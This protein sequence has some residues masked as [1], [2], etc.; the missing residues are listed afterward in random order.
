MESTM[1]LK[2]KLVPLTFVL[3]VVF[4]LTMIYLFFNKS[5]YSDKQLKNKNI[6]FWNKYWDYWP[7]FDFGIGDVGKKLHNYIFCIF[8]FKN[9]H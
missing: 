8:Q 5:T 7:D 2:F 4:V 6:L 3:S 9:F 1:I